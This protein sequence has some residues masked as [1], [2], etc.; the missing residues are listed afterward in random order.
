MTYLY[1]CRFRIHGRHF[2]IWEYTYSRYKI[3]FA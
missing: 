3:H 1:T 2:H